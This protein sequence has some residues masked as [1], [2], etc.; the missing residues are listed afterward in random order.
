MCFPDPSGVAEQQYLLQ[1]APGAGNR[2]I[3]RF[4]ARE[5]ASISYPSS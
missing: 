2:G 1:Q 3:S 4:L 5:P